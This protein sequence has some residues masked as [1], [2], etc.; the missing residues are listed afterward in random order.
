MKSNEKKILSQKTQSVINFIIGVLIVLMF[1]IGALGKMQHSEVLHNI[2][3]IFFPF[4]LAMIMFIFGVSLNRRK[5]PEDELSRE[6]MLKAGSAAIF[7]V[8]LAILVFGIA[9]DVIGSARDNPKFS[10]EGSDVVMFG[11]FI[12]GVYIAAKSAVFLWLDR[13]PKGEEEE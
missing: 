4:A 2:S 9:M 6:L 12:C 1:I 7:F 5:Q 11:Q 3:N 13:T 10:I 8:L